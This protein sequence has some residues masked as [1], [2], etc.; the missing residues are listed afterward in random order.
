MDDRCAYCGGT[1]TPTGEVATEVELPA[2]RCDACGLRYVR[3]EDGW[4]YDDRSRPGIHAET[5]T[6]RYRPSE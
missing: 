2:G 4:I 5:R 6:A 1:I 3:G